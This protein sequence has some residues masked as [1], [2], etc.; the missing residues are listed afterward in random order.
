DL[1]PPTELTYTPPEF[2]DIGQFE[3]TEPSVI[4]ITPD[5][6]AGAVNAVDHVDESGLP[7]RGTEPPGTLEPQN[8]ESTSGTIQFTAQDGLRSIT[9]DGVAIGSGSVGTTI[10][11]EHGTLTITSVN[12]AAGTVGYSYTATDNTTDG[13]NDFE[14][15]TIIVTD[16]DG[17][18][19]TGTLHINIEDD[20][21]IALD[22]TD[23]V[24]EAS[25]VA[26]GNVRT[27]VGTTSGAAGHDTVGADDAS[28]TAVS[29]AHGSDSTFDSAGNLVVQGQYG[30]L[31]IDAEGN[32]TYNLTSALP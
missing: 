8:I 10:P 2:Q 25:P 13:V 27:G 20:E 3:D 31:T 29:G 9:I 26:T 18:A 6:P 17:D 15:F 12:L 7:A 28:L 11:G 24:T 32:Y 22:D 19:A 16:N 21:P 5:N 1:I 14:D 30:T 4:I 23:S